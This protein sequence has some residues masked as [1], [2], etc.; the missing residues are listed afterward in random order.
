MVFGGKMI[1]LKRQI[2]FF[3][4]VL[5]EVNRS[6]IFTVPP[7]RWWFKVTLSSEHGKTVGDNL[8]RIALYILF[9]FIGPASDF[10]FD[11]D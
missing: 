10:P 11:I 7:I 6:I 8:C 4:L 1:S 5:F 2:I 9:V 3:V